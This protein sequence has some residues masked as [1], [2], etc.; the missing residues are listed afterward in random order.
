MNNV[1]GIVPS[2][3]LGKS[4]GLS[5]IPASTCSY[6][7]VYCQLGRTINMTIERENFF[8][9][10][11]LVVQLEE[12]QDKKDEFDVITL[13]GEGEPTLYSQT[14]E[15]IRRIKQLFDK[16]VALITN[17]SL[18][19]LDE[20]R[21]D[22]MHADIVM[23]TLDAWDDD[24]FR[25]L[26][27]PFKSITFEKM[28]NGLLE[29]RREY[30][31]DFY[32][33]IMCVKRITD[34]GN[35]MVLLTEKIN[36]LNPDKVFVNTP[37]RPPAEKWVERCTKE[38]VEKLQKQF[39]TNTDVEIPDTNLYSHNLDLYQAIIEIIK[40]HPLDQSGIE[41]FCKIRHED[42]KQI[43]ERLSEDTQVERI[44]YENKI[45]YRTKS[46]KR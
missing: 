29:F 42:S 22:C 25:T 27:R 12:Y 13:V 44:K 7:C 41:K 37:V 19:F 43:I 8:K 3:R 30:K 28:Y 34:Q 11:D 23:P 21:K 18:F 4:L 39:K 31:G 2:R 20:V 36:N 14:G 16:P 10:D 1:Y 32:V 45:F 17:G 38:F 40:R 33:E 15:L 26:N 35:N 5:T 46:K 9:I 24:S 6:S